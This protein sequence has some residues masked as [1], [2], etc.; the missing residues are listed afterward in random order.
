MGGLLN[1]AMHPQEKHRRDSLGMSQDQLAEIVGPGASC[2]EH[3]VANAYGSC[4]TKTGNM[5]RI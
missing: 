3:G 4:A 5:I 1:I 2:C